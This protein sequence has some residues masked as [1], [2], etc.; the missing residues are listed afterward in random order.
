MAER[1][2]RHKSSWFFKPRG[3]KRDFGRFRFTGRTL[4][5]YSGN[6]LVSTQTQ[7]VLLWGKGNE[8][9]YDHVHVGPPYLRGGP[10]AHF[11]I[12]E[13]HHQVA[14]SQVGTPTFRYKGDIMIRRPPSS[15]LFNWSWD[16]GDPAAPY[17]AEGWNKFKPGKPVI[18]LAQS[19]AELKDAP[20]LMFKRMDSIKNIANNHLAYEFGWKPILSDLRKLATL[21][22]QLAKALAQ[23]RADN[24]KGVRR[25]GTITETL[26]TGREVVCNGTPSDI[27]KAQS[28]TH[29]YFHSGFGAKVPYIYTQYSDELRVWFSA[30]FHYW[31]PDMGTPQWAKRARRTL[32]GLE[33]TPKLAWELMP[34]S[35]LIDWFSNA[36]DVISNLTENAAENLAASYSFVM[37][38][39][40][41]RQDTYG[42]YTLA[43]IGGGTV[44]KSSSHL[45]EMVQHNRSHGS[46]YGFS[47]DWPNFS[48]RQLGILGSLGIQRFPRR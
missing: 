20:R 32:M 48:S 19:I 9:I 38:Q 27:A 34:W 7:P 47:I 31:I 15:F 23:L 42:T 18:D 40:V 5:T 36:G 11:K 17:G 26:A 1:R 6:T 39:R 21:Q 16:L 24:G 44:E 33:V 46:P 43:K 35:W 22:Q 10:L 2:W 8:S 30:R 4:E 3:R 41:R 13:T 28:Y 14:F 45:M 37:R 29:G 12:K 25:G